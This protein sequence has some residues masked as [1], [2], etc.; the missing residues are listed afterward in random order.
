MLDEA[1]ALI[2]C[3]IHTRDGAAG[4]VDDFYFDD[5]F[6]T[7]RYL[8]A[9]E[10]DWLSGRR[11][12]ISPAVLSGVSRERRYVDVGLTR[13]QIERGLLAEA[14]EPVSRRFELEY[15]WHFGGPMYWGFENERLA[16]RRRL[17][18][19]DPHLRSTSALIG[20]AIHAVDGE[21]GRIEDFLIDDADWAIRYLIVDAHRWLPGRRVL[22]SPDWIEHISWR[23]RHAVTELDRRAIEHAPEYPAGLPLARDY[24]IALHRHY[25]REGYWTDEGSRT[26]R[27]H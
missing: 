9:S 7:V 16:A 25:D 27:P 10:G 15:G 6:W 4:K 8:V 24:E 26:G 17:R 23:R 11:V 13:R 21:I 14:H 3:S 22:V 12:L 2:G 20:Y 5:R 19:G 1:R 18:R